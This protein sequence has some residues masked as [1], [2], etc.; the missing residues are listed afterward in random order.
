[1]TV[2][3]DDK[4]REEK[5]HFISNNTSITAAHPKSVHVNKEVPT[6]QHY[7]E[8]SYTFSGKSA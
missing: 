1:M 3:W 2:K 4:Q 7:R 5:R 8:S 6:R